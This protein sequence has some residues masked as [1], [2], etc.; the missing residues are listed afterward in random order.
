MN[1]SGVQACALPI[2][3][4][5]SRKGKSGEPSGGAIRARRGFGEG[6]FMTGAKAARRFAFCARFGAWPSTTDMPPRHPCRVRS[7]TLGE[8]HA[9]FSHPISRMKISPDDNYRPAL[10]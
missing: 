6:R 8:T 9:P 2:S 1:V 4:G 7:E 5:R 10:V 3:E